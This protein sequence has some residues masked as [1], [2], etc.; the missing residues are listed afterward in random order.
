MNA[1]LGGPLRGRRQRRLP[2][3]SRLSGLR[4]RR[5]QGFTLVELMVV[6]LVI[7]ILIAIAIPTFLAARQRAQNRTAQTDIRHALTSE[8]VYFTDNEAYTADPVALEDITATGTYAGDQPPAVSRTVYVAVLGDGSVVLGARS[9]SGQCFYMKDQ[10]G[11]AAAGTS[12]GQEDPGGG[13]CSAP[14]AA[15]VAAQKW[16]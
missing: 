8:K 13:A 3:L 7:A 2:G 10:P 1:P 15:V 5:D 4:G 12:F 14:G 16:T 11:G 6:V 9:A